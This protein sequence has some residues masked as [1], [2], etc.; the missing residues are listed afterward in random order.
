M[1]AGPSSEQNVDNVTDVDNVSDISDDEITHN[2]RELYNKFVMD[3]QGNINKSDNSSDLD[4]YLEDDSDDESDDQQYHNDD[5]EEQYHNDDND[6]QYYNDDDQSDGDQSDGNQSDG[7]QSGNDDQSDYE[8]DGQPDDDVPNDVA[9]ELELKKYVMRN[10]NLS[11]HSIFNP[12]VTEP[13]LYDELIMN[14]KNN[15]NT[16]FKDK[17]TGE[18]VIIDI[19]L[20]DLDFPNCIDKILFYMDNK[21][22]YEINPDGVKSDAVNEEIV[23][24]RMKSDDGNTYYGYLLCWNDY[25]G[26][27]NGN[28]GLNIDMC[29]TL[30]ELKTYVLPT[31]L[32]KY[33][34]T[35]LDNLA[36]SSDV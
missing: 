3:E 31:K 7:D 32:L 29:E 19:E 15:V 5:N 27:E 2:K 20:D 25:L 23:I 36:D 35:E 30:K 21:L 1:G 6:Q 13:I 16:V 8:Y 26:F 22:D 12:D 14:W 10:D 28:C 11:F 4:D 34:S 33:C 17:E 9:D 24:F 18:L